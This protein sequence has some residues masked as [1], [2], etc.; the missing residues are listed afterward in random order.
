MALFYEIAFRASICLVMLL[1]I[2][3]LLM[4]VGYVYD[5]IFSWLLACFGIKRD[6]IQF[7]RE[8]RNRP[9]FKPSLKRMSDEEVAELKDELT[10]KGAEK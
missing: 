9:T 8:R 2:G 6:L 1:G 7:M 4:A 10:R 3:V 5:K